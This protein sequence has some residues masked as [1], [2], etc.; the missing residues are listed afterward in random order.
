MRFM[1][2]TLLIHFSFVY[3]DQAEEEMLS[4]PCYLKTHTCHPKAVC[5]PE[6]SSG[7]TCACMF[8]FVDVQPSA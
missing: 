7:Y 1:P 6:T 5:Q 3:S 8:G 4:N 2:L